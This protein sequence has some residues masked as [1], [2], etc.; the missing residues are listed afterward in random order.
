MT[1]TVQQ[2]IKADFMVAYI[3]SAIKAT[4]QPLWDYQGPYSPT[5]YTLTDYGKETLGVDI[6]H[7]T[8]DELRQYRDELPTIALNEWMVPVVNQVY[9]NELTKD[10]AYEL[11][12]NHLKNLYVMQY[13]L[14]HGG[15]TTLAPDDYGRI[16]NMLQRQYNPYLKGFIDD[17]FN[18]TYSES[19]AIWRLGLYA[20]SSTQG[21]NRGYVEALELPSNPNWGGKKLPAWP[22]GIDPVTGLFFTKCGSNCKCFLVVENKFDVFHVYWKLDRAEHCPDCI[23]YSLEWNPLVIAK[24]HNLQELTKTERVLT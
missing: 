22:G 7:I 18:Y 23:N 14:S 19:Y 15:L 13:A 5:P 10:Q 12:K 1:A 8:Q 16:G 6:D 20:N 11:L 24:D 3:A 21:F 9:A 4:G 17:M 2:K